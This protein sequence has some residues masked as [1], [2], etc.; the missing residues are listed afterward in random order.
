MGH[1]S[2][3]KIRQY[4]RKTYGFLTEA[5]G[6]RQNASSGV[7]TLASGST[8]SLVRHMKKTLRRRQ[9]NEE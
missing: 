3:K 5:V 4:V 6:Y 9:R 7:I 8:R 2:A 1:R